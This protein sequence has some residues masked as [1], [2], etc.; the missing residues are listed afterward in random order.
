MQDQPSTFRFSLRALFV[1]TTLAGLGL[2]GLM[3]ASPW[4]VLSLTLVVAFLFCYAVVAVL[5]A[6]GNR[7]L[8]WAAFAATAVTL[9]FGFKEPPN[10]VTI[11][12]WE[13]LFPG[14]AP[15]AVHFPDYEDVCSFA[16]LLSVLVV[17]IT[18]AYIIP[19]LV[20]RGQK[21]PQP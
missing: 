16:T 3:Y 13:L 6:S 11:R 5:A 19:W 14:T 8:F 12:L 18:T 15:H 10:L 7:R 1:Y 17:S 21:P 2:A 4:V 20:Q 9:R